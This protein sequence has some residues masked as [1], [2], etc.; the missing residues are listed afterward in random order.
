MKTTVAREARVVKSQ[1]SIELHVS[2]LQVGMFVSDLDCDWLETPFLTQGFLIETDEHLSLLREYCETVWVDKVFNTWVKAEE[3]AVFETVNKKDLVHQVPAQDEHANASGVFQRTRQF[4]KTL[5]DEVRLG[6][7]IDTEAAKETV[8]GCV[9]SIM[10]NPDALL[11][12]AKMRDS[13]AYTA[14]HSMSVC[15]LSIAFGRQLGMSEQ[16]LNDLGLCAILHDVGKMQVPAEILNKPSRLTREEW[17]VMMRHTVYGRD[18]LLSTSNVLS[19]AIDVAYAHHERFDGNGYPRGLKGASIPNFARIIAVADTY[20]AITADRCYAPGLSSNEALKILYEAR[21]THFE[22]RL[23]DAFMKMIGLYPPGTIVE[24]VNGK[25][26]LVLAC[27]Q[28]YQH[29]PRVIQV[30]DEQQNV[31]PEKVLNLADIEK[32]KLDKD[33]FIKRAHVDGAF[34]IKMCDFQKK[35]IQFAAPA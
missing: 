14:E 17:Q 24:L 26:A 19:S 8:S 4:T 1:S 15:I 9:K 5:M 27:N 18:L 23:V 22:G 10:N 28:K 34:G 2:E 20:D 35:G 13:D 16:E 32:G 6:R 11:W 25:V 33:N 29:L 31:V 3:R 12:M 30:L 7:A 21:E